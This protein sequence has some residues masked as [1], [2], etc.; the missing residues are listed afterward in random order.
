MAR[1]WE[2]AVALRHL[3]GRHHL[4]F[5]SVVTWFSVLGI[6]LGTAALILVLAVMSG[7]E[8]EVQG[9]IIG[10]DA[11]LRVRSW[12]D[13]GIAGHEALQARLAELPHLKEMQPYILDKGMLRFRGESEGAVIRGGTAQGLA[14]VLERPQSIVEGVGSTDPLTPG[15]LPGILVGRYLGA[16]LGVVAGDTLLVLSPTGIVSTFSQPVVRRFVVRGV[17]EL[18]IY[19]FD[20]AIAFIDLAQAQSLFRMPGEVTGL[21][22]R[23]DDVERAGEAKE[24]LMARLEM[25][26]G[27]WTWY[28]MHKNLFSMMKLEKWMMFVML[29]LIVLVAAF[30]IISVLTMVTME[31]RREIG[32][33]KALGA[34]PAAIRRI[35]VREGLLLGATGTLLGAALGLLICWVQLRFKILSLPPD[36]YFI[37]TF[38]VELRWPD[39]LEVVGS[40]LLISL[41]A[42]L[43]PA[44]RAAGLHPVEVIRHEG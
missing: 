28:D 1:R 29:S 16:S 19:E 23:L 24:W 5:I 33:L 31:R 14:T 43:Y 17:F 40:A 26:L 21:E 38:P 12:H 11:H 42:T 9:R 6:F 34:D 2:W 32:I 35:F 7:F 8:S 13:R 25:P 41:L 3:R 20:D 44:W 39:L 10:L 15:G 27:A 4:G 30:N 18:G 37:S 36:V 22:I